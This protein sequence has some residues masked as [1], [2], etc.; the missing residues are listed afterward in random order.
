MLG[1]RWE[2]K[3][4]HIDA[5]KF[6]AFYVP[7]GATVEVYATTLHFC[8]CQVSDQGFRC[9][10]ALPENTNVALETKQKDQRL[11]AKNKWLLAHVENEGKIKQGA[12]PGITGKNYEIQ[13]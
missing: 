2:I 6:R 4:Q 8:P 13:Y 12:L 1:H 7:K 10:V 11:T 5:S 3:N 9:V